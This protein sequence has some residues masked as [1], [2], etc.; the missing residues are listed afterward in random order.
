MNDTDPKDPKLALTAIGLGSELVTSTSEG[1]AVSLSSHEASEK[2]R[3]VL[4]TGETIIQ[5]LK[6]GFDLLIKT[7]DNGFA[8]AAKIESKSAPHQFNFVANI[9]VATSLELMDNGSIELKSNE[10]YTLGKFEAPWAVDDN[11][12][13]IDTYYTL[14]GNIIH[15]TVKV[16]EQAVYPI[17]ADP[18]WTWGIISGTIYFNQSE[19]YRICREPVNA[20]SVAASIISFHARRF[21]LPGRIVSLA[22]GGVSGIA[23]VLNITA[24]G[25]LN[26]LVTRFDRCLKVKVGVTSSPVAGIHSGSRCT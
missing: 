24:C 22:A 25:L 18:E 16:S 8:V 21:A 23:S 4:A 26:F 2:P 10:G 17:L 9:P 13:P 6:V 19:T 3:H 12:T 20:V 1:I 14:D 7:L 11:Y 15:Q 5:D